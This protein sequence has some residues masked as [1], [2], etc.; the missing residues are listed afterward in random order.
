MPNWCSNHI[1]ITGDKEKIQSIRRVLEM[2]IPLDKRQEA[3][4][5][6]TLVGIPP[7]MSLNEYREK[8]YNTNVDNWGTKWDVSYNESYFEF[9]ENRITMSPDTAWSPPI[10]FAQSL[11]KRYGVKVEMFYEEP[12]NDFCGRTKIDEE[13]YLMEEDYTYI[14][15]KYVLDRE[16][17]W[18][19]II[20]NIEFAKEDDV[21]LEEFILDYNYV[22]EEDKKE[23]E[24]L[25]NESQ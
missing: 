16:G 7:N 3:N 12:G 24:K 22:T 8:W 1:T 5:F 18:N 23:I 21:S 4:V 17:F 10:G 19:E 20:S 25:Y 9:S 13:G 14:R 2:E 15:G 11:C 6:I